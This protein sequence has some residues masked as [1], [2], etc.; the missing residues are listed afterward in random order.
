V[1]E[2][3]R[4]L[5]YHH[6]FGEFLQAQFEKERPDQLEPLLRR[7]AHVYTM[8]GEWIQA[9]ALYERIGDASATAK[10]IEKAGTDLIRTA[11]YAVLAKWLDALPPDVLDSHPILISHKGT[12]LLLQGQVEKSLEYLNKAE[13]S[14]R[15]N[16]D[17]SGLARTLDRRASAQRQLGNYQASIQDGMEALDLST[18]DEMLRS[19]R[20]GAFR[21]TGM[22]LFY[23]GQLEKASE[24]LTHSLQLFTELKDGQNA[25]LSHMELGIC[26][27]YMGDTS[28]AVRQ[29][30][31]ALVYWQAVRNT[32]RQSYVLNNLGSLHQIDGDYVAAAK[33][34]EQALAL[35]RIN[36]IL[37]SEAYLLFNLG[38]IYA[39]LGAYESAKDAFQKT[40][41]IC[42]KLDDHFLLLN[43]DLAESS[44]NRQEGKYTYSH[45]YL[46]SAKKMVDKSHS[47]FEGSLWSL[48]AGSL[49]LTENK[50]DRALEQLT[51]A[52]RLFDEGG[53]KLEA[54]TAALLLCRVNALR[55]DQLTAKSILAR[56]LD[57]VGDLDSIQP[58]L[59][60]GRI[61]K[62]ELKSFALDAHIGPPAIKLLSRIE[63][64]ERQIPSLR[65]KLRPHAAT[66]LLIPPK[67]GI[68]AL[69]KSQVRLDGEPVTASSWANQKRARELFFYLVSHPD[70][71]LTKEEI[72]VALWPE[73]SSEQL[74]LQF[75]NTIYYIRYALGQEVITSNERRY[76]FNSDM[77]YGYDV[78]EFERRVSLVDGV[79]MP[80][81]KIELLQEALKIYQGE[82]FPEGEGTWVMAERQRLSQIYEHSL[83]ELTRLLLE[84]GEPKLALSYS[85]KILAEN[86]CMESAHC[87]AMQAFAALGDRSGI[88]NQFEQCKQYLQD[89][90][91]LEPSQETVKIYKLLR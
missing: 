3:G 58:M 51:N 43:V 68:Y 89:E 53:Q 34:F 6:L 52:L 57:L 15:Q 77:D 38:N 13:A 79:E 70:K 80:T 16:N 87:L 66:V 9:Y 72:G 84:N 67:L 69:G 31:Q 37:H 22:S 17:R 78:Q 47:R 24:M 8:W 76:G 62:E 5:R 56:A 46:T 63:N 30:E 18:D 91:G 41:N 73:S 14:Q 12:V 4:W 19:V 64:F 33:L 39:D 2:D 55:G 81:K 20:A 45:A 1:G 7:I 90:L 54:A 10:L 21:T 35:A 83:L 88:A 50:L 11:Q 74:R 29:S 32:S 59:V 36:G 85:Q 75:R 44:L 28:Q 61:T 86:H 26:Y 48:E 25:A 42:Q 60:V 23:Q 40:R 65:R 71:N 49:A 82:F 27:Q